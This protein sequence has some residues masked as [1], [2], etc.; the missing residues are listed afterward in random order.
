MTAPACYAYHP[1]T[2]E[3]VGTVAVTPDPLEP[4]RWV[5]PA[6]STLT[7]P[8][9]RPVGAAVVY[10][11]G[12]WTVDID[13]RGQV[14]YAGSSPVIV[15]HIGDPAT[16]EPPLSPTPPAVEP[17]ASTRLG[18]LDFMNLFTPA[19]QG[20]IVNS[21][22]VRVKLFT[23]MAAGASFVD[24]TDVRV[25]AGVK[26]LETLGLISQGRALQVLGGQAAA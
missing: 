23:L 21:S 25:N 19:E 20:A 8:P 22:D 6:F 15:N 24:L 7:P 11:N 26:L 16:F 10:R 18:F 5:E 13:R 17:Q 4:G 3:Y 14:W 9:D 2:G 1:Q 12:T